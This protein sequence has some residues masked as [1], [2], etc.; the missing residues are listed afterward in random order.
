MAKIGL[1]GNYRHMTKNNKSYHLLLNPYSKRPIKL[2]PLD[3]LL[4]LPIADDVD[5]VVEA[6]A[7]RN[8]RL[9]DIVNRDIGDIWFQTTK[10]RRK[11][12]LLKEL[13]TNKEFFIETLKVFKKYNIKHYDLEK[14]PDGVYRWL[15]NSQEFVDFELTKE[16]KNCPDDLDS[17][18]FAVTSII[19]HFKDT[20]ENKKMWRTF[21]TRHDTEYC[22]VKGYYSHMLFYTVCRAWLV[23]QDSN[24]II[25]FKQQDKRLI[26][27]FTIS[28]K[29]RLILHITH[30]NST[31]L[32]KGYK[33]ILEKYRQVSNEKHCCLIMNFKVAV[34]KQLQEI[35]I[36]QNPICEI[37]EIDVTIKDLEQDGYS[38][39]LPND[40]LGFL[41]FEDIE[42]E[43]SHYTR[44]KRK[45]GESSY[46]Q[47]KP[48]RDKV[49]VLC[50]EELTQKNYTSARKLCNTVAS[51]IKTEYPNLLA[52]YPPYKNS[53]QSEGNDWK[54]PRLYQ[55]CN[56]HFKA[57]R[58]KSCSIVD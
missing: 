22:H 47:Y 19:Q 35:R 42:F 28:G 5:N 14:D 39:N 36:I 18:M 31:S 29:D 12:A 49:A 38:I 37:F 33:G 16:A 1:K 43:D 13:K 10:A 11:E 46:Q 34:S 21:W 32:V 8:E 48:M 58:N 57:F 55:W 44:E 27:E 45:G 25:N 7:T 3:I 41:M 54:E 52:T 4:K 56:L 24:I 6:L 30:A 9:R 17:L 20:I 40:E 53:C 51:R 50:K 26:L 15:E 2:V 23:S